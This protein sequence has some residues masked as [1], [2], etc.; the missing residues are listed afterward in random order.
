MWK[1]Q[2]SGSYPGAS[3]SF[4]GCCC[5]R[6]F[7]PDREHQRFRSD[8]AVLCGNWALSPPRWSGSSALHKAQASQ[9]SQA[10]KNS[11]EIK[12]PNLSLSLLGLQ[13]SPV[14]LH[15]QPP[16]CQEPPLEAGV[17]LPPGYS[18]FLSHLVSGLW[19]GWPC[20]IT[21][22]VLKQEFAC[23][24]YSTSLKN[25]KTK[26]KIFGMCNMALHYKV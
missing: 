19:Q 4:Q 21:L 11:H 26:N 17:K 24:F 2:I 5:P 18:S 9:A 12:N 20:L 6:V 8:I 1:T 15:V 16:Q 13:I 23:F 22:S 14:A 7:L 3:P 10:N 25:W